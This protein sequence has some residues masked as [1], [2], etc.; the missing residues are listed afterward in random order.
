M[1]FIHSIITE[2]TLVYSDVTRAVAASNAGR[3][4]KGSLVARGGESPHNYGTAADII[5]YKDGKAVD[6]NSA[7]QTRFAQRVK[8]LS[9]GT[10]TWGGDWQKKG[11]RRHFE[12]TGWRKYK[13]PSHL[14][15]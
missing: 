4:R 14:V 1:R 10:I 11:E 13:N 7:L 9:G 3:A 15:G 6:V 12:L 2:T 5:L 8:E